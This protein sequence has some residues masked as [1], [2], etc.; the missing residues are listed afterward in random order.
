MPTRGSDCS[1]SAILM[2]LVAISISAGEGGHFQPG[3]CGHGTSSMPQLQKKKG[4]WQPDKNLDQGTSMREG[5][6]TKPSDTCPCIARRGNWSEATLVQD[7]VA[8]Q[9]EGGVVTPKGIA[10]ENK[11]M[12][13]PLI[14][15]PSM[16]PS[17]VGLRL[18]VSLSGHTTLPKSWV[19][20]KPLLTSCC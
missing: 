8:M 4:C 17:H 20:R 10:G 18:S 14:G 7:R 12:W 1:D 19:E 6:G 9:R 16:S 13:G 11:S 5:A 3:G 15:K 2:G